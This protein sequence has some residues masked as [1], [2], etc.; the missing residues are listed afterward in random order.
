MDVEERRVRVSGAQLSYSISGENI[1]PYYHPMPIHEHFAPH[2]N[3]DWK[4]L[5]RLYCTVRLCI[6]CC[7]LVQ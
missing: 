5:T 2:F 7:L 6:F 1:T 4:G 3:L